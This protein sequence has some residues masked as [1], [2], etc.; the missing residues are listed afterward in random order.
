MNMK[1]FKVISSYDWA[2]KCWKLWFSIDCPIYRG[3]E[4]LL[5]PGMGLN[6]RPHASQHSGRLSNHYAMESVPSLINLIPYHTQPKRF[7][8]L[9]I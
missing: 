9:F 6:T 8:F 7:I 2:I 4:S 5:T 3:I 1:L